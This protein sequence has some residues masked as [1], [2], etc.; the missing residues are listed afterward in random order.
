MPAAIMGGDFFDSKR[1]MYLN[2]GGIG[3]VIGHE[4][5]HGFDTL[6]SMYDENGENKL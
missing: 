3:S 5:T 6:G 1:P 2:F 4:V